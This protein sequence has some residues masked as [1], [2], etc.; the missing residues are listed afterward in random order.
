MALKSWQLL[1]ERL[2]ALVASANLLL[3]FFN[4]S[5]I[6]WRDFWF[7]GRVAIP[8][9]NR[10]IYLPISGN[11]AQLYD[12]IKGI[13]PHRDTQAYLE[14]VDELAASL[15]Q[16]GYD[17]E[18]T[19]ALLGNLRQASIEMIETNPFAL[20]NKSGSLERI[21]NQMRLR[22]FGTRHNVSSKQA[23]EQ[24]WSR[25]F[26]NPTMG[27]TSLAW[28]NTTVRPLISANY[29]RRIGED[30]NFIDNFGLL[31]I[32]FN[33]VFFAEF[34]ARTYWL[35]RHQ[36][37]MRWLDAMIS[38]WYDGLLFFPFWWFAPGWAWLRIIPV[39]IRLDQAQ[40]ISLQRVRKQ[41]SQGVVA[42]IA[43]DMTEVV[44]LQVLGQMQAAI[45]RGQFTRFL[46]SPV[47]HSTPTLSQGGNEI[48]ELGEIAALL[49][50]VTLKNVLPQLRPELEALV[51]YNVDQ[52]LRQAPPYRQLASFPALEALP[53]YWSTQLAT[54]ITNR[55][56]QLL[57]RLETED[58]T[59]A[60][61]TSQLMQKFG[62]TL[63]Y[64][65]QQQHVGEA[66]RELLIDWLEEVKAS[67]ITQK[68]LAKMALDRSPKRVS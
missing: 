3:V 62:T 37:G 20:A 68:Q 44:V 8:L 45:R 36:A 11:I 16:N 40:I 49:M 31:D 60:L 32:P 5:Y 2:M 28:F 30:G 21:K 12:P 54:E 48:D 26:I 63:S 25:K 41:A 61:L 13:E 56:Y 47:S 51:R 6:P 53:H 1:Y 33:L 35:G 50:Q 23:F 10:V 39:E 34:L 55:F 4:L 57:T 19:Q 58:K 14:L 15:T 67:F 24:F 38:R 42:T 17:S 27:A 52:A 18:Q 7:Q 46:P 43:D 29:Y 59:N 64:E 22:V 9:I 65:I 66:L